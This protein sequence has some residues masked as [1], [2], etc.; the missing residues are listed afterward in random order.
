MF[1]PYSWSFPPKVPPYKISG[2][3]VKNWLR[4]SQSK[5]VHRRVA[6][7]G[8]GGDKVIIM[9]LRGPNWLSQ[10]WHWPGQLDWGQSVA[11]S[12]K[13]NINCTVKFSWN[14]TS[15]C[16]CLVLRKTSDFQRKWQY[17]EWCFYWDLTYKPNPCPS[18]ERLG[19]LISWAPL[20]ITSKS[21]HLRSWRQNTS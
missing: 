9:P 14:K 17:G 18:S 20:K 19:W 1:W 6:G 10:V 2:Q 12:V 7:R 21:N 3:S 11:K 15:S 4:Y 8:G 16:H 13:L 5:H